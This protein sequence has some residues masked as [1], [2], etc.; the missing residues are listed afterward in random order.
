M[1]VYIMALWYSEHYTRTADVLQVDTPSTLSS[2]TKIYQKL[3]PTDCIVHAYYSI[4]PP[5][6]IHAFIKA[7]KASRH[8]PTLK[9]WKE[10]KLKVNILNTTIKYYNPLKILF[11]PEQTIQ[12]HDFYMPYKI[13]G[14]SWE[15]INIWNMYGKINNLLIQSACCIKCF[16][17]FTK[18]K[19]NSPCW[20]SNPVI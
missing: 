3:L 19:N 4:R 18:L 12:L 10:S 14:H 17:F 8:H 16:F 6:C 13:C 20:E 15:L 2:C 11:S 7:G 1:H 5:V 9:F